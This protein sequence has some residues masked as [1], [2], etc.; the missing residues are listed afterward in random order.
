MSS[1][2]SPRET[3][4]T[5][6]VMS[7]LGTG[8]ESAGKPGTLRLSGMFMHVGAPRKLLARREM[9]GHG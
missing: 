3:A 5:P 9:A 4:R 1:V 7:M 6:G 2:L 8:R